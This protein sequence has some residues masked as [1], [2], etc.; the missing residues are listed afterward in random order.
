MLRA[1]YQTALIMLDLIKHLT[2]EHLGTSKLNRHSQLTCDAQPSRV[3]KQTYTLKTPFTKE[4]A[5]LENEVTLNRR[6]NDKSVCKR[7]IEPQTVFYLA[8]F[9]NPVKHY[10]AK[11]KAKEAIK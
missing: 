9:E 7:T 8:S 3:G 2:L 1:F 6:D 10:S 4:E 11:L 5:V